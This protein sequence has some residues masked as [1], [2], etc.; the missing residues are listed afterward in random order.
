MTRGRAAVPK[1]AGD[2]H[3]SQFF[4]PTGRTL[5][6]VYNQANGR[7]AMTIFDDALHWFLMLPPVYW[8]LQ[9]P[10]QVLVFEGGII[11][12]LFIGARGMRGPE[13]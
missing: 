3:H 10:V 1:T 12:L 9:Q 5:P 8:I 7:A 2:T 11:A 4:H 6:P 13:M